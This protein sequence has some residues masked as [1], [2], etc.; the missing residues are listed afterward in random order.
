MSL[1]REGGEGEHLFPVPTLSL[2]IK[3]RKGHLASAVPPSPSSLQGCLEERSQ[4]QTPGRVGTHTSRHTP[5][6]HRHPTSE[7]TPGMCWAHTLLPC[8]QASGDT[9][10]RGN[11]ANT[12]HTYTVRL[13]NQILTYAT[14]KRQA[15]VTS[16]AGPT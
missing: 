7:G 10:E 15:H 4:I 1:G 12:A 14:M 9:P 13:R 11:A 16:R 8:T 5:Q 2:P 6:T 3:G